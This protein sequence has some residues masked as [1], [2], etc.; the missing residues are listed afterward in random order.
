[1]RQSSSDSNEWKTSRFALA[2][3]IHGRIFAINLEC[4][5]NRRHQAM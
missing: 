2:P 4:E 1:V 3:G 5:P